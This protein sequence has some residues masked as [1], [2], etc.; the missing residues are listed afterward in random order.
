MTTFGFLILLRKIRF[1]MKTLTLELKLGWVLQNLSLHTIQHLSL[2]QWEGFVSSTSFRLATH[3][4]RIWV[5]QPENTFVP[6]QRDHQFNEKIPPNRAQLT[7]FTGST[8]RGISGLWAVW[9]WWPCMEWLSS[10]QWTWFLKTTSWFGTHDEHRLVSA[11]HGNYLLSGSYSSCYHELTWWRAF[12][13]RE[14]SSLWNHTR[15]VRAKKEHHFLSP[16]VS[17]L[18]KLWTGVFMDIPKCP[19]PVFIRATLH[20]MWPSCNT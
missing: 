7:C 15:T 16:L 6:L 3:C 11:I 10:C 13:S 4:W 19:L 1:L 12:P 14:C 20:S 17:N 8:S 9:L 5:L 18:W 2:K